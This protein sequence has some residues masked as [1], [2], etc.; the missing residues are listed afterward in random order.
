MLNVDGVQASLSTEEEGDSAGFRLQGGDIAAVVFVALL[1]LLLLLGLILHTYNNLSKSDSQSK[2]PADLKAAGAKWVSAH[3]VSEWP[4]LGPPTPSRP[5]ASTAVDSTG[6]VESGQAVA[7]KPDDAARS[8]KPP[9]VDSDQPE[10]PVDVQVT[11]LAHSVTAVEG[12]PSPVAAGEEGQQA[13]HEAGAKKPT[14]PLKRSMHVMKRASK[15]GAEEAKAEGGDEQPTP[16]ASDLSSP[17]ASP[18]GGEQEAGSGGSSPSSGRNFIR[19]L[20]LD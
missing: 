11:W 4:D 10:S 8:D 15:E 7:A 5:S 9:A 18:A 17:D 12:E 13:E 16:T 1:F 3:G 14:T 20:F 6:A 2:P 19:K